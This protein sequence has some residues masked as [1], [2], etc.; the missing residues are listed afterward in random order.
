MQTRLPDRVPLGL[1]L[2][3]MDW[4]V[5]WLWRP[6]AAVRAGVGLPC[7]VAF[8]GLSVAGLPGGVEV[9]LWLRRQMPYDRHT[10]SM[11]P[12]PGFLTLPR[13]WATPRFLVV[14]GWAGLLSV[15]GAAILLS[16]AMLPVA[17]HGDRT[18]EDVSVLPTLVIALGIQ[19]TA[20]WAMPWTMTRRAIRPLAA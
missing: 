8:G 7:P 3:R 13:T 20:A 19:A 10:L 2:S 18:T 16:L 9:D 12:V 11:A 1:R 4:R 17:L 5:V 15:V 14:P 6:W